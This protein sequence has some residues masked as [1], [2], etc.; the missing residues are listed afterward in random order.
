MTRLCITLLIILSCFNNDAN[1]NHNPF[2]SSTT[3]GE[4]PTTTP[5]ALHAFHLQ[6]LATDTLM[7]LLKDKHAVWT[8]PQAKLSQ[9]PQTHTIWVEDDAAHLLKIKQLINNMDQ[10]PHQIRIQ[11]ELMTVNRHKGESLGVQYG[12][13]T[14]SHKRSTHSEPNT[15]LI[16]LF[17]LADNTQLTMQLQA[18][19]EHGEATMLANPELVTL[20]QHTATIES[21]Q[22]IPYQQA[23]SSGGTS[24]TFKDAALKLAVTPTL[25]PHQRIRLDLQL[26]QDTVSSL[27]IAGA[28]AIT[29][30]QLKTTLILHNHETLALGGI[31]TQQKSHQHHSIPVLHSLPWVGRL[32]KDQQHSHQ[33]DELLILLTPHIQSNP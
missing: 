25:L 21:G 31:T 24:V 12:S 4:S 3:P 14:G 33:Q 11:A 6:Y 28:P 2:A 7:A 30:Q 18:L 19:L 13:S 16:P 26:N 27:R 20:D 15:F 9:S 17:T 10:P 8:S 32:F 1:A 23:T 5:V 29:T 22:E